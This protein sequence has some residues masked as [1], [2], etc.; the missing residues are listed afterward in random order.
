MTVRES[1]EFI[2][3]QVQE[4]KELVAIIESYLA[5]RDEIPEQEYLRIMLRKARL[6]SQLA[7]HN[8]VMQLELMKNATSPVLLAT[9]TVPPGRMV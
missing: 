4:S 3:S 9:P 7:L 1:L 2:E 8:M 5:S 6:E